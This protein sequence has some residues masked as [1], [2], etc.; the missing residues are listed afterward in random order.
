M[1]LQ[2]KVK[3]V[4]PEIAQQY[5]D[6][7][8]SQRP[9]SRAAVE[10]F[11]AELLNKQ[12]FL[13]HQ[14]VALDESGRLRDGQDRLQAIIEAGVPAELVVATG[15][16]EDAIRVIDDGRRRT[17]NHALSMFQGE[18]VSPFI[19]AI[20]REMFAGGTH[21]TGGRKRKPTKLQLLAFFEKYQET[22]NYA[23]KFFRNHDTGMSLSF[24]AAVIAR[25][26]VNHPGSRKLDHFAKV[27]GDGF[28]KDGDEQIIKLRNHILQQR[29]TQK[30]DQHL[31]D[32]LYAKTERVL[33]AYFDREELNIIQPAKEELFPLDE[34]PKEETAQNVKYATA[35]KS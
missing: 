34:D 26:S 21:L 19:T 14:G 1:S 25:A 11:K 22:I 6:N 32:T 28:S 15:L 7:N 4:T 17:D 35:G 30:R 33:K 23:A 13:T 8:F 18:A 31:R 29:R 3:K 10:K 12:F 20:T 5:M 24:I 9:I 16:S 2:V 27:L